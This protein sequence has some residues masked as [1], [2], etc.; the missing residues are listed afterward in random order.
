MQ[1][2]VFLLMGNIFVLCQWVYCKL[3]EKDCHVEYTRTCI[4]NKNNRHFL[5]VLSIV[6]CRFWR[7]NIADAMRM[8]YGMEDYPFSIYGK[9]SSLVL[10]FC[11][12]HIIKRYASS[13]WLK[14]CKASKPSEEFT[15]IYFK[16]TDEWFEVCAHSSPKRC[17]NNT[18]TYKLKMVWRNIE[19]LLFLNLFFILFSSWRLNLVVERLLIFN[20]IHCSLFVHENMQ[21]CMIYL[22]NSQPQV[23]YVCPR[24]GVRC[25]AYN[26]WW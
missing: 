1:L 5:V 8:P 16:K 23:L 4:V 10:D 18:Y 21:I 17:N 12:Q 13:V 22:I 19:F 9:E 20:K 6:C 15:K 25:K 24:S 26:I 11:V 3:F 2:S 14:R 7:W